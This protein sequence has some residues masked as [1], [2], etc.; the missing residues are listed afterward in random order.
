MNQDVINLI[1]TI[2][3]AMVTAAVFYGNVKARLDN[4]E[5]NQKA[6]HEIIERLARL[7]EKINMFLSKKNEQ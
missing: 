4:L 3:P 7:E 2:L 1:Q 5:K 6:S